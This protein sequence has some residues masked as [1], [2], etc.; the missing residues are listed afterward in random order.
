MHYH[1]FNH[2]KRLG[3]YTVFGSQSVCGKQ[4]T[5]LQTLQLAP[6]GRQLPGEP[7]RAPRRLSCSVKISKR[8]VLWKDVLTLLFKV[9]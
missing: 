4:E 9:T 7:R 5:Q 1:H 6:D 3:N 8:T 2:L